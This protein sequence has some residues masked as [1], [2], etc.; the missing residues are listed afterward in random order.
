MNYQSWTW[1]DDATE[2]QTDDELNLAAIER[3]AC[4]ARQL[5][6]SIPDPRR[7]WDGDDGRDEPEFDSAEEAE[8]FTQRQ[9]KA[10]TDKWGQLEA[11]EELMA[12]RGA[13]FARPYEHHNE[14][15]RAIEWM[16][17]DRDEY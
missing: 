16:E 1:L 13:R 14:D 6:N 12:A 8:A 2:E 3:L 11:I 4:E 7:A 15:E 9:R 10:T 5:F 17:R